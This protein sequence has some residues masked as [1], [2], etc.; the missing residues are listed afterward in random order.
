MEIKYNS[1][2]IGRVEGVQN[3]A[4]EGGFMLAEILSVDKIWGPESKILILMSHML[5][6]N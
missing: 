4:C 5:E 1:N 2:T 6:L 3:E